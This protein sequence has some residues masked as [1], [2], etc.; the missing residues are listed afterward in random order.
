LPGFGELLVGEIGF[1]REGLVGELR[2]GEN[3][4]AV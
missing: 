1:A 3:E 4:G 2:F